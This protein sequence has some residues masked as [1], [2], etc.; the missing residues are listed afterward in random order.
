MCHFIYRFFQFW[1]PPKTTWN[2]IASTESV[3]YSDLRDLRWS[4]PLALLLLLLRYGIE[5]CAYVALLGDKLKIRNTKPTTPSSNSALEEQYTKSRRLTEFNI[6]D[7]SKEL[8]LSP[9]FICEWMRRRLAQDEKVTF[10]KFCTASWM[11]LNHT[12]SFVFGLYILW[13]QEYLWNFKLMLLDYPHH[14]S[15]WMKM[16][17]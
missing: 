13:D 8:D 14:V 6:D 3:K 17:L 12:A 10:K 1:L 15:T 9:H 4:I 2:D 16:K 11:S 7:L 5:K